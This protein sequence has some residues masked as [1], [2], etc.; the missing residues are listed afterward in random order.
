MSFDRVLPNPAVL[1]YE[2]PQVS[3]PGT[4]NLPDHKIMNDGPMANG[5]VGHRPDPAEACRYAE[6]RSNGRSQPTQLP[7][8]RPKVPVGKPE[9][10][11]MPS[12]LNRPP[13]PMLDTIGLV[14]QDRSPM[15]SS[16]ASPMKSA[17]K[18][19]EQFCLCQPDPKI[20]RPRNGE[21]ILSTQSSN[22]HGKCFLFC[23]LVGSRAVVVKL[24][25]IPADSVC[26]QPSFCIASTTRQWSWP[27]IRDW[28]IPISQRSL[29]S[30]G[31]HSRRV[32][33]INGELLPR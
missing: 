12:G 26:K 1:L 20:P 11:P 3:L 29:E 28:R 8:G 14:M 24:D 23:F 22:E 30:S 17:L 25:R 18:D 16:T 27:I 19:N 6:L 10:L 32:R 13:A 15:P 4:T 5:T 9:P 33:R 2:A 31:N 7:F 21:S